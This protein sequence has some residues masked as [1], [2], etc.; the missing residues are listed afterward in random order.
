MQQPHWIGPERVA[1]VGDGGD[2]WR[3]AR[4]LLDEEIGWRASSKGD[5]AKPIGKGVDGYCYGASP[6]TLNRTG[7][8]SFGGD[9]SG[10]LAGSQGARTCCLAAGII[11]TGQCV[12]IS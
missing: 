6:V 11:D 5:D 7:T 10:V 8:R 12:P 1:R 2:F 4:D 9:A 3:I